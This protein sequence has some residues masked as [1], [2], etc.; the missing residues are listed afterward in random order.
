MNY[1]ADQ[2]DQDLDWRFAELA[3][4][5]ADLVKL[6]DGSPKRDALIRSLWVMLYAHYEGFSKF[7]WD[8]LLDGIEATGVTV[9][10]LSN[11]LAAL[12]LKQRLQYVKGTADV[13]SFYLFCLQ[14]FPEVLKNEAKFAERYQGAVSNLPPDEYCRLCDQ[15]GLE[16]NVAQ[17]CHGKLER[18]VTLRHEIAHGQ[19]LLAN[20]LKDYSE[21]ENAASDVMIELALSVV[22]TLDSKGYK[23]PA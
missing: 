5:K 9:G 4:I 2:L 14:D 21:Y 10:E 17:T 13:P 19:K 11:K 7:A 23:K 16:N 20:N 12:S 8:L 22:E 3:L 1:W 15:L 6:Q 18:L